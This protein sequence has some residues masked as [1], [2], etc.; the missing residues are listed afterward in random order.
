MEVF[1]LI[2]DEKV[3]VWRRPCVKVLAE[4]LEEAVDKCVTNG[5]YC[6]EEICDIEC[7]EETAQYLPQ[8]DLNNPVTIEIMNTDYKTLKTNEYR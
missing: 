8:D 6:A 5:I 3:S 2:V 4:S 1:E 7:L